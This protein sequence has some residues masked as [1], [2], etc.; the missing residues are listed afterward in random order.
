MA[1]EYIKTKTILTRVK[2]DDRW[3]RYDYGMNLYRGC[4][5]RCIYCDSRSSCYGIEDFDR[6]RAKADVIGLLHHE[7]GAKRRPGIIGT[8]AMSDPYNPLE[9]KLLLTRQAL[10]AISRHH[11]GVVVFTKSDLILRDLDLLREINQDRPVMG[12]LTITAAQDEM[13]QV[14]EPGVCASS[15]RFNALHEL[16]KAGIFCGV[17][18]MP[19]LPFITDTE[20]NVLG[21][22]SLAKASGARFIYPMFGVTLRANQRQYYYQQLDE[23][24]PGLSAKYVAQ[25]GEQ[26]YCP[27]PRAAELSALFKRECQTAGLIH[28]LPE[29]NRL[30]LDQPGV[31]QLSFF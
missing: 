16:A 10:Q 9:A 13:S 2:H 6:V 17:L 3:F 4:S 22:I 31:T 28:E 23:L 19:L 21:I 8:G 15:R 7:L 12:C 29:I 30:F 11:F 26:Y 25:Y 5:H 24:F 27:S 18:M 20:E 1:V 14:V